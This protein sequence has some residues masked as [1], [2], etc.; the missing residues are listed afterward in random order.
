MLNQ[1]VKVLTGLLGEYL[2]SEFSAESI[3][4]GRDRCGSCQHCGR[5]EGDDHGDLHDDGSFKTRCEEVV[6]FV[7][8]L[9]NTLNGICNCSE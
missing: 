5:E 1:R 6:W 3:L 7:M 2:G 8:L 4:R 9:K